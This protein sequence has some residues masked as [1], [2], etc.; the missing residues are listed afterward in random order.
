MSDQHAESVCP[1]CYRP[2]HPGECL[3]RWPAEDERRRIIEQLEACTCE[4]PLVRYRNGDGHRS[5]CP[6]HT[7]LID[8]YGG[9]PMG[10]HP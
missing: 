2:I 5:D 3:P 8:R 1:G 7:E 4:Y 9:T 6:A 10:D